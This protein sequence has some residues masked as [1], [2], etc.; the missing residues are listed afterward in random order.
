MSDFFKQ[1]RELLIPVLFLF[2]A[3][4]FAAILPPAPVWITDSGNK[5]MVM[6]NFVKHGSMEF[7]HPAPEFFHYCDFHFQRLS[8]GRIVSFFPPALPAL[9]APL[10]QNAGDYAV[11]LIPLL[12]AVVILFALQKLLPERQYP[13]LMLI[14][15][16][17][18]LFYA[19]QLWEMVPA[20]AAVTL[21][22]W[23]FREKKYFLA[24]II[25]GCG[26]WMREE[27]YLLGAAA[28]IAMLCHKKWR[29]MSSFA[30]GAAI[31]VLLLWAIN[32]HCYG[33]IL[34]IHGQSN[35]QNNR[36]ADA[37]WWHDVCFNYYQQL[38]RFDT[39]GKVSLWLFPAA[40]GTA[41][42]AGFAPSFA[43]WK[44]L[45]R[46]SMY[47]TGIAV[48]AAALSL[49]RSA[50]P[51]LVSA[52]T[53]GLFISCP[54]AIPALMNHRALCRSKS[55]GISLTA[56][57]CIV[58]ILAVPPFLNRHDI[59]LTW[60][61]RHYIVIMPLLAILSFYSCKCS[62]WLKDE[63]KYFLLTL[64]LG[65][66]I[67]QIW[68]AAALYQVSHRT[69]ELE[70]SLRKSADKVIVTDLFFLPEMTPRLADENLWLEIT[71][72]KQTE[73]LLDIFART[74]SEGF[75]LII[76]ES[77]NYRR[78]PQAALARLLQLYPPAE[79]VKKYRITSGIGVFVVK[80]AKKP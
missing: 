4:V 51:L 15:A 65:G 70:N 54:L 40:L 49:L 76:S 38:L 71:G 78:L 44:P 77:P 16:S 33:H 18:L 68:A 14:A 21:A 34:G 62:R 55:T 13:P 1:H 11:C 32:H 23:G 10:W 79:P 12:S 63:R 9:T 75:T 7:R 60:G 56:I 41:F 39:A 67:M 29:A 24:G 17:P 45:K 66:A 47:L 28:G 2:F 27:L 37:V 72:E 50:D 43:A 73:K 35:L 8:D 20:A 57:T 64:L 59:G 48:T 61:S 25:F 19:V 74:G 42:A 58:F 26:V 53:A 22:A 3:A 46:F 31:P 36:P 52:Q 6:Q 30:A 69:A 80:C 5:Y